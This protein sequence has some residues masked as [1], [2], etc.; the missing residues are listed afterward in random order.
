MTTITRIA[1][2]ITLFVI[3]AAMA[4]ENPHCVT[5]KEYPLIITQCDDGTV[6]IAS[7]RNGAASVCRKGDGCQEISL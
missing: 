3:P 1:A 4:G 6:T 2:L 5:E 7:V